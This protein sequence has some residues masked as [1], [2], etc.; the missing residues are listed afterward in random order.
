[1]RVLEDFRSIVV[2]FIASLLFAMY[3][4]Y[5][6][7]TMGF[8]I[9]FI[10][11]SLWLIL[12][13]WRQKKRLEAGFPIAD[14]LTGK[15]LIEHFKLSHTQLLYHIYSGGLPVYPEDTDIYHVGSQADPMSREDVLFLMSSGVE[16]ERN[17]DGLWFRKEDV[18]KYVKKGRG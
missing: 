16:L 14:Y 18:E 15:N 4:E 17:L 12:I 7:S 3:L 11:F 10:V 9:I 13:I 5:R 6:R 2:G 1:M 8:T